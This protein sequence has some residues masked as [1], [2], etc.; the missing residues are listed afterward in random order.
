MAEDLFKKAGI[1]P[2]ESAAV[3][4]TSAARGGTKQ[5]VHQ[6]GGRDA[7]EGFGGHN[8]RQVIRTRGPY[9]DHLVS[10]PRSVLASA[11]G[12]NLLKHLATEAESDRASSAD[13]VDDIAEGDEEDYD[14][15]E[16]GDDEDMDLSEDGSD[17][18]K[19]PAK[20]TGLAAKAPSSSPPPTPVAPIATASRPVTQTI[21][22]TTVK[23]D[24]KLGQAAAVLFSTGG[25]NLPKELKWQSGVA[26]DTTKCKSFR[27]EVTQ[28]VDVTPF[29]FMRP[30]SPFVQVIHSI[31]TYAV[32]G[33]DS[34]LH[35]VDFGYTGD[36]TTLRIP[37]PVIVDEKMWKWVSKT[38]GL[39]VPPL[40]QYYAVPGNSKLLYHDDASGGELTNVPRMIH[41]PPPFLVYCLEAPRTP[42]EL[43]Q[44]VARY[45]TRTGAEVTIQDCTLL[46]DWCFYAS[47]RAAKSTPSTSMLA[48]TLQAAPS[49]DD[50]FLRWLY[51]IDSTNDATAPASTTASAA[52]PLSMPPTTKGKAVA[53]AATTGNTPTN[54]P[55]PDVWTQMAKSISTSFA[56]AAA[57]LKPP[58]SDPGEAEYERGG[59]N[60]DKFQMAVVQGFAQASDLTGVL[61]L[62]ALFQYTKNIET[63][64]DNLR[65]KMMAW[66]SNPNPSDPKCKVQV[67]IERGLYIPDS[68]IKEILSLNFNPGGILAEADVADLGLS[69]LICRARTRAAKAAIRSYEKA[70]EQ[71]K[72]NRSMAEAQAERAAHSA[73]DKG[74]LPDDYHELMRCIG[75]YCAMLHALFGSRCAFYRHCHALWTAL[76]SDLVY[77]QRSDFSVLYCRQIVWAVLMESRVYFSQRMS[78]EDFLNV[79][80]D[81]IVYPKSNLLTIVQLVRD[82]S[83]IVRSSFP[84]AWNPSGMVSYNSAASVTASGNT[85]G[86]PTA[87]VQSI[88]TPAGGTTP[89]VV[90]GITAGSAR[91]Q[92]PPVTIRTNDIHPRIKTVMEPYIAKNKG[93]WLSAILNHLNL[94][95]DD[96]PRPAADVC[97]TN[98]ICYNYILGRCHMDQCQHEHLRSHDITE[99]FANELIAKL[100]P[101]LT[102][103]TTNGV[104][105]AA[106]RRQRKRRRTNA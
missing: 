61:V 106:R 24:S 19:Q 103:F 49:D 90:S 12:T 101:G 43:H 89:S 91:S 7:A 48:I 60:Y 51:K 25:F 100:R 32:R 59:V 74:A 33:G 13:N 31:A 71:S 55:P 64:K 22:L 50:D 37:T 42:F 16:E 6:Q 8:L 44:F 46:M 96:L 34:E 27:L 58:P 63:H 18:T 40:E 11:R 75:T 94:T 10:R 39:D 79:H 67:P 99:D 76:N 77:E 82:M 66:A 73:Y 38:M 85:G 80:P 15:D 5:N 93:V 23:A 47:H 29:G 17:D 105:P 52:A 53:F 98:S 9:E 36:R 68:T 45:A 57:S 56:T 26:G 95:M 104:P 14:E 102:E 72:R 65:R 81:D 1:D 83:P 78:L 4:T 69:P 35:N 70:L 97:G 30:S 84:A 3:H 28:Q 54:P 21:P 88:A 87:P 86:H 20:S 92:R 41:L 62:W 2:M